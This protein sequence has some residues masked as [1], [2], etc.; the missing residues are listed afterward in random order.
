VPSA[1]TRPPRLILRWSTARCSE[2]GC[3]CFAIS[4]PATC[5]ELCCPVPAPIS[6]SGVR[7]PCAIKRGGGFPLQCVLGVAA[8][9]FPTVPPSVGGAFTLSLIWM[10]GGAPF[11]ARFWYYS[12][13]TFALR[14]EAQLRDAVRIR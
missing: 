1:T 3:F 10:Q 8:L 6:F 12:D 11:D 14:Y 7:Q 4:H 2:S 9:L 13:G 5:A